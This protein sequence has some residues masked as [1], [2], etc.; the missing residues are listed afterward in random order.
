MEE[1]PIQRSSTSIRG[2]HDLRR[3][4]QAE[5]VMWRWR[6][7]Q[8]M[9]ELGLQLRASQ[10]ENRE[11][12][13]KLEEMQEEKD[14]EQRFQTPEDEK[15]ETRKPRCETKGASSSESGKG[16]GAAPKADGNDKTVEFM[17]LM[18]QSMQE[19]QRNYMKDKATP[20]V[21]VVR[22]NVGE[23]PQLP[24]WDAVEA[25]LK[26]G[27]GLALLECLVSDLTDSSEEWWR[28]TIDEVGKWYR[29][30]MSLSPLGRASH[31]FDTPSTLTQ[32]RWQRLEKRVA[33]MLIRS[34]PEGVREDLVS[35]KRLSTFAILAALQVIYQPGGLGE[36]RTLL[37]DSLEASTAAEAVLGLRRWIRRR[38]RALEIHAI[39]PDPTV[40]VRGL[41]KVT[42]RI[43]EANQ[44]LRFRVSLARSS[45]LIDSAPD[46]DALSKYA[47][48]LLAEV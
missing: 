6:M 1:M 45:L 33:G 34:V 16:T 26:M 4:E 11:L 9:K 17:M 46:K 18:L 14:Y 25:P 12:K 15:A 20:E 8:D 36:K 44:E 38:Q 10:A 32:R 13:M 41:T 21:E 47:T 19:M 48:H 40:L 39:E 28:L 3:E 31:S 27:D 23:F 24:E 29:D 35:N 43:L 7:S 37:E 22:G 2:H 42:A 30:H 5:E